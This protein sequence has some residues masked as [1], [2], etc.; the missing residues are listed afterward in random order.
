MNS[1]PIRAMIRAH[2]I[3]NANPR[4]INEIGIPRFDSS[5]D[6]HLNIA[7]LSRKARLADNSDEKGDIEDSIDNA[8]AD[9]Y[10]IS[11]SELDTV[12]DY[13]EKTNV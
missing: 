4:A 9:L 3:L 1:A 12:Y 2:S 6:S 8:I 10:G 5:N 7:N 13:L 11:D